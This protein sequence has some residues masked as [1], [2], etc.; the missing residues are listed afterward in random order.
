MELEQKYYVRK[1]VTR[2]YNESFRYT[3]LNDR[4]KEW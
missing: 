2:M 1:G 3:E 4:E